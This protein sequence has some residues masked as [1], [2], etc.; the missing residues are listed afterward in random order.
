MDF[1]FS[2]EQREIR[3]QARR[4]LADH[5]DL[6]RVRRVLEGEAAYDAALWK[7]IAGL[8]W[9][10]VAIPEAYGGLG[11]DGVSLCVIAEELGRALAPLPVSSSIYLAAQAIVLAGD[12]PTKEAYLPM[13]AGGE[14]IG[15][16]AAAEGMTPLAAS[17]KVQTRCSDR[18]L[19]GT[20]LPVPDGMIAD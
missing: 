4:L 20:K 9:L 6:K 2:S 12:A 18:R 15:T 17:D 5:C 16:L 11:L 8:G 14:T 19:F 1:D 10:G 13:L 7:E 3:D